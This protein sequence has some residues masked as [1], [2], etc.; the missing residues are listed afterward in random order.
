MHTSAV[1]N[2]QESSEGQSVSVSVSV[3]LL[4]LSSSVSLSP[5]P[6]HFHTFFPLF[7]FLTIICY[8]T[9]TQTHTHTFSW[10][11]KASAAK[12]TRH[13]FAKFNFVTLMKQPWI[14]TALHQ[15][16][17]QFKRSCL[18]SLQPLCVWRVCARDLRIHIP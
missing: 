3:S 18:C 8:L 13:F 16:N 15:S 10:R 7:V 14:S 11:E 1:L 5:S 17:L 9:V 2:I 6:F 4:S 12:P